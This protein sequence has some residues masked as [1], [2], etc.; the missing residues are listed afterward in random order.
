M[1]AHPAGSDWSDRQERLQQIRREADASRKAVTIGAQGDT[2][3]QP[4]V[5]GYYGMP[6]LKRPQW[7]TEVPIYFFVGGMAGAAAVI[8]A[9][10]HF[11]SSDQRLIRNSRWIAAMGGLISPALLISDLGVPSRFL[12]MLRVFKIQ[13]PMSVGSWTLVA[14]SNSAAAAAVFGELETR[15]PHGA[16]RFLTSAS[17][18]ASA[19]TGMILSTYTGVLIGATAI[20]V[21]NEHI[22]TLPVHFAAS[23]VASAASALELAGSDSPALNRIAIGAAAVET[24]MGASIELRS[25]PGSQPL[26]SGTSGS[27]MRAAGLLSGPVPL[28]L[29]LLALGNKR[30]SRGLRRAA[31]ISS[32]AGS[33]LTRWAWIRAGKASA[34][35]PAAPLQ[36]T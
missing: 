24:A 16:I 30:R 3:A 25:M 21:W 31:A 1:T 19:L 18:I 36:Q 26:R 6:A 17:Q 28:V 8:G 4:P 27:A 20:P 2:I 15:W 9:A 35:D 13:S 10:G 32:L 11:S 23:G 5:E 29:R 7:T 34:N 12:N 22:S 33:L 14:F